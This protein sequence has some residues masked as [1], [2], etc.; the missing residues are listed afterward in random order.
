MTRSRRR[1]STPTSV[2]SPTLRAAP[3]EIGLLG[4]LAAFVCLIEVYSQAPSAEEFRACLAKH[5][6]VSSP[7][8]FC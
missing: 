3:S 8:R 5:R 1:R 7:S 4:P 6:S 2:T